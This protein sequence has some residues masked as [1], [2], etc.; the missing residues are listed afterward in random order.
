MGLNLHGKGKQGERERDQKEG[1]WGGGKGD[2]SVTLFHHRV[3]RGPRAKACGHD[4]VSTSETDGAEKL[5][6]HSN[7]V[8]VSGQFMAEMLRERN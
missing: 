3:Q 2:E 5:T 4:V 7:P 6:L 1:R 8:R